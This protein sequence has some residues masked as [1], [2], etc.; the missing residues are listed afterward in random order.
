LGKKKCAGR[1]A[2]KT[3]TKG[4]GS[5]FKGRTKKGGRKGKRLVTSPEPQKSGRGKVGKKKITTRKGEKSKRSAETGRFT[6]TGNLDGHGERGGENT[7]A[8]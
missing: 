3:P 5:H 2:I 6:P 4:E 8:D 1:A 7:K